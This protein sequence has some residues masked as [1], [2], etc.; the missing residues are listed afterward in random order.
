MGDKLDFSG[1]V[2]DQNR[3]HFWI[4]SD[5]GQ[6]L[7]LYDWKQNQVIQSFTLGYGANGEYKEIKKAE[8]VAIDPDSNRLFV[9]SDKEARLYVYNI[10]EWAVNAS[11][12]RWWVLTHSIVSGLFYVWSLENNPRFLHRRAKIQSIKRAGVFNDNKWTPLYY[13][14]T[15]L[16]VE[17]IFI[18]TKYIAFQY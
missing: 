9:V 6:R 15:E 3:K 14:T 16:C 17:I 12:R 2:Y 8:G 1:I 7:F 18:K 5:K 13:D 4:V 10:Q 11:S